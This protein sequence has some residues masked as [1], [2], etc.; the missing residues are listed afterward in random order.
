MAS[1][2]TGRIRTAIVGVEKFLTA[3]APSAGA[4]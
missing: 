3:F 4:V 1:A 2:M